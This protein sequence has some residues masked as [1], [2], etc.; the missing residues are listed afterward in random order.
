MGISTVSSNTTSHFYDNTRPKIMLEADK[1]YQ[2]LTLGNN[3]NPLTALDYSTAVVQHLLNTKFDEIDESFWNSFEKIFNKGNRLTIKD[4]T[5]N[6]KYQVVIS[7]LYTT[8]SVVEKSNSA[9]LF[10]QFKD[11]FTEVKNHLGTRVINHQDD[12]DKRN[13]KKILNFIQLKVDQV[14]KRMNKDI[15]SGKIEGFKL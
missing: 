11:S 9:K 8:L 2:K 5:D 14:T 13:I 12:K 10:S 1:L 4:T 3:Q 15:K 7:L 6:E